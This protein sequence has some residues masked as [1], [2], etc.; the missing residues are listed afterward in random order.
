LKT[1]S[2]IKEKPYHLCALPSFLVLYDS[3]IIRV[4][5]KKPI[6]KRTD[7]IALHRRGLVPR[8]GG[9][10]LTENIGKKKAIN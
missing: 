9:L 10:Y 3:Q 1:D 4:L 5:E 2:K 7:M 8:E 6:S